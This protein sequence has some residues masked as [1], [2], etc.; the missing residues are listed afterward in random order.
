MVKRI[1]LWVC[2]ACFSAAG[3]CAKPDTPAAPRAVAIYPDL[4]GTWFLDGK[5]KFGC[6]VV[7]T[8][9]GKRRT[10]GYLNGNLP[11]SDLIC[12]SDQAVMEG[13]R[14]LVDLFKV[15]HNN[16]V[17]VLRARHRDNARASASFELKIP[18]LSSIELYLKD[19]DKPRYGGSIEPLLALQWANGASYSCEVSDPTAI[20]PADSVQLYFNDM[21]IYGGKVLL[22]QFSMA[23][24]HAF[25][26]SVMWASKP[27]LNDVESF[28]Y[29]GKE[30]RRWCFPAAEGSDARRQSIAPK[31]MDGAE[32]FYGMAGADARDVSVKLALS[33]DKRSISVSATNGQRVFTHVFSVEEFSLEI[34]ARG[35]NGG[36]GGRGGEGGSA[37]FGDPYRAGVGGRGGRGGQGG[38]GAKITIDSTPEAELFIPC[39]IIDN[40]DGKP[41]RP[42]AGGKGGVFSSGYGTPTLIELLFPPRNYDGL[43]GEE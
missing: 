10:T 41:G 27:W 32:G 21:R 14:V 16:G 28:T 8:D 40:S 7:Y 18:P 31:G 22:P 34:I 12:E 38:K 30:H 42:G 39:I 6:E 15:R 1:I 25:T 5:L 35:G 3:L 2:L 37:P 9:G 13:D 17:L 36:N 23:E 19:Q 29:I 26:L 4:D 43:P 20:V 11:W 24:P 33:D